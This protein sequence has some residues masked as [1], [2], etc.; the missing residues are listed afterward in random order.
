MSHYESERIFFIKPCLITEGKGYPCLITKG[1]GYPC[2]MTKSK[3]YPCLIM[4]G[5]DTHTSLQMGKDFLKYIH[6]CLI[7]KI[8]NST[9]TPLLMEYKP[10]RLSLHNIENFPDQFLLRIPQNLIAHR[11]NQV[12]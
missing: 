5:K 11:T 12:Y 10:I 9:F 2:L 7:T 6:P 4:K 8:K 1:K 3:G